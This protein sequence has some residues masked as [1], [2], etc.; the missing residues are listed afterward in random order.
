MHVEESH[1]LG[2]V[3]AEFPTTIE[4]AQRSHELGLKVM[5]GA[6]NVVRGGS[7]SGNV[8]AHELATLGVLDALSS[9]YFPGSLIDAVFKLADD[10]RNDLDLAA[11]TRLATANPAS[12]LNLSDRGVVNEGLRADLLL[13]ERKAG[14]AKIQQVLRQGSR[15]F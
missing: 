9:D 15:V 2:L 3:L 5:M 12:A 7:H 10:E 11:A 13:V 4:A 6:P 14:Q 8:A 1:S